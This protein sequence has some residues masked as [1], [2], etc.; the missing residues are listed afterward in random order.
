M[1]FVVKLPQWREAIEWDKSRRA[2]M[3]DDDAVN[4]HIL[5]NEPAGEDDQ[6][7]RAQLAEML[8]QVAADAVKLY[9]EKLNE[10]FQVHWD[11]HSYFLKKALE[12]IENQ[13]HALDYKKV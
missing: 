3:A 2:R 9:A 5:D 11:D 1:A 10:H 6:A 7:W 4:R 12:D 13:D 8:Q